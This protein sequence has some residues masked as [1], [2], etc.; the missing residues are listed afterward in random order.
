[1]SRAIEESPGF[2][3][4]FESVVGLYVDKAGV[5][6]AWRFQRS[7]DNSLT[8]LSSQPDLS[9]PLHFR[10]LK[11]RGVRSFLMERP[12]DESLILYGANDVVLDV[13]R[14]M[15]AA[16]NLLAPL[17]RATLLRPIQIL[18]SGARNDIYQQ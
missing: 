18:S 3:A 6:L 5:E 17:A 1:M 13:V 9:R 7:L 10:H 2:T 8:Q 11:L 4:D 16:R 12:F 15:Y 14:L